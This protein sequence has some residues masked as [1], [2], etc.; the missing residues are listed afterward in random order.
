MAHVTKERL[1]RVS[2]AGRAEIARMA[3]HLSA[4][5]ACRSLAAG[6]LGDRAVSAKRAP[7]LKIMAELAG[8]EKAIA[9]ERLLA[10]AELA[11]LR[12]LTP[13]AQKER[14]IHSR[15]CHSAA[16]LDALLDALRVPWSR[17]EFES[18]ATLALLAAQGIDPT[19]GSEAFKNDLLAMIWTDTANARRIRGEWQP[20]H[21]AL[22][23]AD[24]HGV[25]G[26][27]DESIKAR[28]LA[29][30][31]S[32]QCDQGRRDEAMASLEECRR[33]YA[34]CG[35]WPQV[36]RTLVTM[37]HCIA[38]DDPGRALHLL[39]R[40]H[41]YIPPEDVGLRSLMGRIR[42]DCLV[43]VGRQEE[44]LRAFAE[45][46]RLRPLHDRPSAALRSTFIAAR[47][48]EAL[49]HLREAEVLFDE[50]VTGD[51]E[52]GFYKDA[53]LDLLYVFGFHVRLGSPERAAEA[54]LRTLGEMDR[55]DSAVHEQLRS[56]FARLTE[57]AQGQSLDERMLRQARDYI[58]SHWKHPA[59]SE[60]AF[61][62]DEGR[63][64]ASSGQGSFMDNE[65]VRPL[66][67]RALW[68]LIR[69]ESRKK[70]QQRV[71]ESPECHTTT[72]AE[73][74]LAG[75]RQAPSREEAEFTASLAHQAIKALGAPSFLKHDLQAQLWIEV[76][77]VRRVASEWSQANAA[78]L[79]AR[80]HLAGGSGDPLL[81][82]RAQ[83]ISASLFADQG[84]R[85]EALAALEECVELYESQGATPLVART[86]VQMAHTLV[87]TDPARALTVAAEALPMIPAA[88]T[89]LRCLAENIRTDGMINL[90][91]I[92]LA[93]QTFDHAEP[94]RSTGLSPVAKRRSDFFAARLLEHLGHTKEAVQLFEAVIADAFDH[95][96]YRE[97]FLDLLYLF[98]VHIRHGATQRAVALC[99]FAIA[100]LDRFELGHEQLRAVWVDLMD[101]AH[102][103]VISQEVLNQVRHYL[104]VHWKHPAQKPPGVR[105]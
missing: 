6:I 66:L 61:T 48:L 74:L 68:S 20:A 21:N 90:G 53:L 69:R 27:G 56:V 36:G 34:R 105:A 12:R 49:G 8:F 46:E 64:P 96:A 43:T 45:A 98:S 28:R 75:V 65:L 99:R 50:V 4:C 40:T 31:G 37:A 59:P 85:V 39:D 92:E 104:R 77:N 16:F 32:L 10:K 1:L 11:E 63:A 23:R 80:K 3:A 100:Q 22:L 101:A 42:A 73:L 83:S 88:D 95:E 41:V 72:F 13:G 2:E 60:P 9:A 38:D 103:Q 18:L 33:A 29:I 24:E 55:H 52:Q 35:E 19:E 30:A 47:L 62:P 79:Q 5:P 94:L 84:R 25:L 78:L 102:R 54:S 70:Q 17:E 58:R 26:T 97:A 15:F 44:A 71:A 81:K 57:A 67:A 14:V 91:E 86:L 93:L 87:D 7:L 89:A 51:L 82:A 76:A